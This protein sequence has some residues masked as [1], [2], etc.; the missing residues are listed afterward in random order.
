MLS[1]LISSFNNNTFLLSATTTLIATIIS[2]KFLLPLFIRYKFLDQP[3]SRS[4]HKAAI[5]LGGGLVIIPLILLNTLIFNYEWAIENILIIFLL[6]LVSLIDDFRNVKASVR[7]SIHFLCIAV[8]VHFY[9][10]NE[11]DTY[12]YF[13]KSFEKLIIYSFLIVA[14]AWFINAF[15]FMDG[16]D[17]IT[18]VQV[19]FLTSSLTFLNYILGFNNSTL[20][21]AI[22]GACSGFLIFNW[23]PASIFL[24]DSGSIPL[25]FLMTHILLDFALK[26]FWVASLILPMYYILDTTITLMIRVLNKEKFWKAHSQHFYQ[27]SVRSGKSHSKVCIHVII[28]SSGLFLFA[29]LSVVI[30]NNTIFLLLSFFWCAYFLYNFSLNKNINTLLETL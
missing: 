11:I 27:R 23:S 2:F 3:T 24:G 28:L 14:L 26:G 6:F 15:N 10:I 18:S 1:V 7:L 16:I 13:S 29:L 25:G 19:I 9:L 20:H 22:I 8:Y 12:F 21:Y 30:K 4:N 5:P 17:G